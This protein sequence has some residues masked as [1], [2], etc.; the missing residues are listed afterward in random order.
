M[1]NLGILKNT[2]LI[3]IEIQKNYISVV[4]DGVFPK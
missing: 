4:M 2:I 1:E 3:T